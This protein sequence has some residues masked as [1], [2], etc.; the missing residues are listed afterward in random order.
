MLQKE[1]FSIFVTDVYDI[2]NVPF[3]ILGYDIEVEGSLLIEVLQVLTE[4]KCNVILLSYFL[5]MSDTEVERKM[6]WYAVQYKSIRSVQFLE[7]L[8]NL[9]R[10]M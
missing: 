4:K 1:L 2:G 7:L 5:E 9:W 3:Q 6:N 10:K 8:I